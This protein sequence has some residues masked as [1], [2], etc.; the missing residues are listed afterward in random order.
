MSA[1]P[2]ELVYAPYR[3]LFKR[4]F[5]TA[6]GL[7]DGTDCVFVR[8]RRGGFAGYGEAT[9]ICPKHYLLLFKDLKIMI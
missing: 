8:L 9:H 6:H 3:L 7:R 1:A 4:P 2:L 5:G